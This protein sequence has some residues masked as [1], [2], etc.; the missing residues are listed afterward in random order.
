MEITGPSMKDLKLRTNSNYETVSQALSGIDAG[1]LIGC[2]IGGVLV[3]RF[4]D[5]WDLVIAVFL[6]ASGIATV[7]VPWATQAWQLWICFSII[8]ISGGIANTSEFMILWI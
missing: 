2:I 1:S 7:L 8:G 5:H 6:D 3:D 4:A